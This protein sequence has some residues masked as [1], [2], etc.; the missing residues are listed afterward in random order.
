LRG[1]G[2]SR[3]EASALIVAESLRLRHS[4]D[5]LHDGLC[6]LHRRLQLAGPARTR[7][8]TLM[9]LPRAVQILWPHLHGTGNPLRARQDAGLHMEGLYRSA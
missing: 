2:R 6:R 5:R 1:A 7:L 4:R 8:P 3:A 9:P